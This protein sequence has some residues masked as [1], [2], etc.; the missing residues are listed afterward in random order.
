[1]IVPI[2]HSVIVVTVD[3]R[4]AAHAAHEDMKR[5]AREGHARLVSAVVIERDTSGRLHT[6]P[7]S[8]GLASAAVGCAVGM[9]IGWTGGTSALSALPPRKSALVVEL[10]ETASEIVD[11]MLTGL[12]GAVARLRAGDLIAELEA[13]EI[14]YATQ[15]QTYRTKQLD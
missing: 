4:D 9:L 13:A 12:S 15:A 8:D 2:E 6:A 11:A 7:A 1:V 14:S 5:V 10:E 3:D